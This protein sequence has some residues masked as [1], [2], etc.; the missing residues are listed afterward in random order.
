MRKLISE[1]YQNLLIWDTDYDKV[2]IGPKKDGGYVILDQVSKKADLLMV[3]GV[4]DDIDFE[5]DFKSKYPKVN[6]FL[7]DHTIKDLPSSNNDFYFKSLGISHIESEKTNTLN[8]FTEFHDKERSLSK[9]LKIDIEG[10][11]WD[12]ISE[13]D[14]EILK[15]FDQIIIEFHLFFVKYNQVNSTYFTNYFTNLYEALNK[16]LLLKYITILKKIQSTHYIYHAH[17]NNSLPPFYFNDNKIS[18]D[19]LPQLLELSLVRKDLVSKA[20]PLDKCL[21]KNDLDWSNKTDRPD[22][23]L[24]CEEIF[25]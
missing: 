16:E 21:P 18:S 5:I 19:A 23:D 3:F 25:K 22:F 10:S 1:F 15:Q 24:Y 20:I 7:Y 8:F 14:S 4:G 2:R 17:T 13:I 11:E 6:I 12:L 9:I